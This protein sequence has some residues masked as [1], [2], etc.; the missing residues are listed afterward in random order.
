MRESTV[1]TSKSMAK[2]LLCVARPLKPMY[3][4]YETLRQRSGLSVIGASPRPLPLSS[5]RGKTSAVV[6]TC[7]P[8][9]PKLFRWRRVRQST[10]YPRTMQEPAR[11]VSQRSARTYK[12][13]FTHAAAEDAAAYER[14]SPMTRGRA[15][16]SS[17]SDQTRRHPSRRRQVDLIFSR[18]VDNYQQIF[19]LPTPHAMRLFHT[20]PQ[21]KYIHEH[22]AMQKLLSLYYL[23]EQHIPDPGTGGVHDGQG[24]TGVPG[25]S[26]Q[27]SHQRYNAQT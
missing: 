7:V 5:R 17:L 10:K 16:K 22:V 25:V 11:G 27:G 4:V 20:N 18:P 12:V 14:V 24:Q 3:P 6:N 2:F 9:H 21:P 23:L 1:P 15:K 26:L 19:F 8:R 13:Y